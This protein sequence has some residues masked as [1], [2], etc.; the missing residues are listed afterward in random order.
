MIVG[1]WALA[2]VAN[3]RVTIPLWNNDLVLNTWVVQQGGASYWRYANIGAYYYRV[4]D[5][6]R[7]RD[8]LLMA[9]K[10][11]EDKWGKP[12]RRRTH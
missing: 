7:A 5:Y 11:R 12:D 9:L 2:S 3:I 6:P 4:N 1:A 8:A 10:L